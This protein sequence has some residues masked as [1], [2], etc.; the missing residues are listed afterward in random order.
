MTYLANLGCHYAAPTLSID[1]SSSW[2]TSSVVINQIQKPAGIFGKESYRRPGIFWQDITKSVVLYGGDDY[3]GRSSFDQP[4]T[5]WEFDPGS[6]ATGDGSWEPTKGK[7]NSITWPHQPSSVDTPSGGV[8]VGGYAYIPG[9]STPLLNK[10]IVGKDN[11][12]TG[13]PYIGRFSKDGITAGGAQFVPSYGTGKGL[14][15]Y[16]GG[17]TQSPDTLLS[18]STIDIYDIA[19]QQWYSQT[20]GG[21]V[22][23]PTR[24]FCIIGAQGT[25]VSTYEVYVFIPGLFD[26]LSFGKLISDCAI[27]GL[28]MEAAG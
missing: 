20:A 3:S 8:V 11:V 18:M 1:L 2:T 10:T 25:N 15:V 24:N 14:I 4:Y 19:S 17:Y 16:I 22:P 23:A 9:T 7:L 12:Y 21:D 28:F 27:L 26:H 13:L 5:I 6:P